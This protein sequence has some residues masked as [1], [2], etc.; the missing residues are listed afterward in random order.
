MPKARGMTDLSTCA[1]KR[2]PSSSRR[3]PEPQPT[4]PCS[5]SHVLRPHQTWNPNSKGGRRERVEDPVLL[6]N[7]Q[8][9]S[10]CTSHSQRTEPVCS[11]RVTNSSLRLGYTG[12]REPCAPEWVCLYMRV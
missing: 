2:K 8:P 12:P 5:W 9:L 6:L 7:T 11:F 1:S 10:R 4:E 3:L